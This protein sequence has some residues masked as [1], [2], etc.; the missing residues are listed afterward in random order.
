ML[1][2]IKTNNFAGDKSKELATMYFRVA[3]ILFG[4][5]L[6]F[7][8]VAALQFIVPGHGQASGDLWQQGLKSQHRYF[9]TLRDEIRLIIEDMGT[10]DQASKQVGL[11]EENNWELFPQYHR[12]NITASFVQLEWE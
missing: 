12:R 1:T 7:G 11:N 8:L 5:Q 4:A 6:L 9:T 10:I 2:S 3:I